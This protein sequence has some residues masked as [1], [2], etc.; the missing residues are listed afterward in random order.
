MNLSVAFTILSYRHDDCDTMLTALAIIIVSLVLLSLY[1]KSLNKICTSIERLDGKVALVTG[2]TAGMGVEIATDFAKRGAKVIIAG[3]FE[4]EAKTALEYIVKKTE[5]DKISY[6]KLDLASFAN[7]R[8]FCKDIID[9]EDRLDILINNAGGMFNFITEDGFSAT[10][11]INYTGHF[12]LTMLLLPLLKKSDTGRIVNVAS[13]IHRYGPIRVAKLTNTDMSLITSYRH[14]K[15]FLVLFTK[16]LSKILQGTG[17]T[18]NA[19][20][21]GA[22]GTNIIR[23]L[24]PNFLNK[25]IIWLCYAYYMTPEEGA[26]T[27]IHCAVEDLKDKSGSYFRNCQE[28]KPTSKVNN[29]E[30]IE[31]LW[32]ESIKVVKL[33]G[34]E[35]PQ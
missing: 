33:S 22:V 21:P 10:M 35:V 2:G 15:C 23:K 8:K 9:T 11:Q 13:L 6:K 17:V 19:A 7:V 20:D 31:E 25:F 26:Q 28:I 14:S 34:N 32:R 16:K 29:E 30:L 1:R 4:D 12:L 24:I 3:P 5:S 18:V 27:A